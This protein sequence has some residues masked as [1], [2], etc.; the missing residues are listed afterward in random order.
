[1]LDSS[2]TMA[3][4]RA[5]NNAGAVV[6]EEELKNGCLMPMLNSIS[7]SRKCA[8]SV[9]NQTG[10]TWTAKGVYF[11][12]GNANSVV[13]ET[14]K[15]NEAL[16]YATKKKKG[17]YAT[18]TSGVLTY[19][20]PADKTL[21]VHW[22]VPFNFAVHKN[23]WN[24]RV[25]PGHKKANH[26]LWKEVHGTTGDVAIRGDGSWHEIKVGEG[27][28]ARGAM[29]VTGSAA[30]EIRIFRETESRVPS[31]EGEDGVHA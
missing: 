21:V 23:V 4:K 29:A 12:S 31:P 22:N 18:G 25:Y 30:L 3:A 20:M 14:V 2:R 8:M 15:N 7:V 13:P 27:Y 11:N 26:D 6:P 19:Q 16:L 5:A 10:F 1:M 9:L 17:L 28:V 24:V